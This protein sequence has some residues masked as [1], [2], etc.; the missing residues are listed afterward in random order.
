MKKE[1]FWFL[2]FILAAAVVT[3]STLGI[4]TNFKYITQHHKLS[5]QEQESPELHSLESQINRQPVQDSSQPS[6]TNDTAIN[7]QHAAGSPASITIATSEDTIEL[8][9]SEAEKAEINAML[10]T[11]ESSNN[12]DFNAQL[13]NFQEKNSLPSTG[14]IDLQTLQTLIN[15]A[16]I[17]RAVQHLN[18]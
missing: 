17:Q 5:I 14:V 3:G 13:K 10:N 12:A 16:T 1:Y 18:N 2:I 8:P 9:V 11:I 6:N 15:Q 7:H 4:I